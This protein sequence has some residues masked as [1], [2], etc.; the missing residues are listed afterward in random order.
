MLLSTGR[1]V[2][3]E[4][5]CESPVPEDAR[6]A[7]SQPGRNRADAGEHFHRVRE[8]KLPAGLAAQREAAAGGE[9]P[10]LS[11]NVLPKIREH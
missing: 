3:T 8:E 1:S 10:E 11:A 2:R 9:T 4:G 5:A 6:A 7:R